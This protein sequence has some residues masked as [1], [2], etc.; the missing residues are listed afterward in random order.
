M[1]EACGGGGGVAGCDRE[2]LIFW[3]CVF[4]FRL[5][6]D[7]RYCLLKVACDVKGLEVI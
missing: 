6:F 7:V 3:D 2:S 5:G 1:T 4:E